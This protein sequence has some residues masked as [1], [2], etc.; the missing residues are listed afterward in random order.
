MKTLLAIVALAACQFATAQKTQDLK[1]LKRITVGSDMTLKLVKGSEDKV[2]YEGEEINVDFKD[3]SLQ[4]DGDGSATVY[5]RSELESITAGSDAHVAGNDEITGK[6]FTLTAGSDSQVSLNLNVKELQV[7][8]GS[9]SEVALKG[10]AGR[11]SAT[12]GSDG[13][14]H[15]EKL[16][17]G[18]FNMNLG[19]DAQ[20]IINAKG[21]VNAVVA[22][23]AQLTIHGSP[24][25]VN[26]TKSTDAE[27]TVVQ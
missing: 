24:K 27:I 25:K 19:S 16:S 14:F 6:S 5:Y 15:S 22:S 17:S 3:G 7:T 10:K 21:T 9:D 26:E 4:I 11:V 8:A 2:V 12:I 18:D 23:D 13:E 1:G 20:G